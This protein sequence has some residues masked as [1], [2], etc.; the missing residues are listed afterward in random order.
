MKLTSYILDEEH[1]YSENSYFQVF[2][3]VGY[4][5]IMG[6]TSTFE[7]LNLKEKLI[8]KYYP[9]T[10]EITKLECLANDWISDYKEYQVL[11][12][13]DNIE[14]YKNLNKEYLQDFE[15]FQFSFK[16]AMKICGP[17]G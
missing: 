14:D 10:E 15:F 2:K 11:I 9:N 12:D 8:A 7:R 3:C 6:L 1:R 5:L 13:V 4:K 16:N 17:E